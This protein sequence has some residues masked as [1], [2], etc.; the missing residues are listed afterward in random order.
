[1]AHVHAVVFLRLLN[2]R[3]RLDVYGVNS[4]LTFFSNLKAVGLIELV[5]LLRLSFS[6]L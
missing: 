4:L 2:G 1:M 6:K 5:L 3:P